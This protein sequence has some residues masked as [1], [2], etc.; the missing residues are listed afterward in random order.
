MDR[1][2]GCSGDCGNCGG[3]GSCGGCGG[4]TLTEPEVQVLKLLEQIPFLPVA[5]RADSE[6]PVCREELPE[7]EATVSLA[8]QCLEKKQLISLDYDLPLSGFSYASY[9][10]LPVR[11]SMAL[12]ARGQQV[13]ELLSLQGI[14]EEE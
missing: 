1:S 9:A 13:L 5:R 2:C 10:G 7:D 6:A 11:G 12:T 14:E 4:L 3:C 8:L